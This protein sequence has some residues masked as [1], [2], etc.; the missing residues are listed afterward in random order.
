MVAAHRSP[1]LILR[2]GLPCESDAH[3]GLNASVLL[4][5]AQRGHPGAR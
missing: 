4:G 1:P 5:A 2:A 3:A